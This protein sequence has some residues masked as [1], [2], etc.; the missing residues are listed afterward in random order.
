M[1]EAQ[2]SSYLDGKDTAGSTGGSA[3]AND[4]ISGITLVPGAN[5]VENNFGELPPAKLSGYVYEDVGNDGVKGA[6]EVGIAGVTVT[7]TGTDDLDNAVSKTT[8][9]D[10]TGDRKSVV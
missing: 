5:S 3:A 2:P 4:V 1:T 7:L 8:T 9:T 6:G 10:A